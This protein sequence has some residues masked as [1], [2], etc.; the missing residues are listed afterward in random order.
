MSARDQAFQALREA[1]EAVADAEAADVVSEA[2]IEA[3]AKVRTLL[4]EAM[5]QALLERST[6]ELAHR[7]CEPSLAEAASE[8][9]GRPNVVSRPAGARRAAP[10]P[11]DAAPPA[12]GPV[13]ESGAAEDL[14]WYVYCV[15]ASGA[16]NLASLLPGVADGH[17]V[18]LVGEGRLAAVVSQVPLSEFEE[19]ALRENLNDAKWLER[20][21]RSH[22]R[23][24]EEIR[25]ATTVVPMRLCRIYRSEHSV[26]QMLVRE[27]ETLTESLVRVRGKTEWGLKIFVEPP[28]LEGA[29]KDADPDVAK[30]EAELADASPGAAYMRSKQLERLL[31]DATAR[32]A[33]R[34]VEDVHARLSALAVEARRN[35]P[36]REGTANSAV[37]VLDGA[38][39]V[40]DRAIDEFHAC[41]AELAAGY[42]PRGCALQ[43]TG[44]WPPYNFVEAA[45]AA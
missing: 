12:S 27:L 9:S 22:H 21:A 14:V 11:A 40:D 44:P 28:V 34:C 3:R 37:M 38:Y 43:V 24:L 23:V 30:L 45:E 5:T 36:Q 7:L 32:L 25:A 31:A 4:V 2:R 13:A 26:R 41:V 39:L 33:D 19:Q 20:T 15:V 1:I 42:E 17:H 35:P 16:L 10:P 6:A 18:K 8:T 29:A